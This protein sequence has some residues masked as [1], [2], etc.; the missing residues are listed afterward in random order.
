MTDLPYIIFSNPLYG[1]NVK[2]KII[3][4]SGKN[5]VDLIKKGKFKFAF[6]AYTPEIQSMNNFFYLIQE[7]TIIN[8]TDKEI[9]F[10]EEFYHIKD[11]GCETFFEYLEILYYNVF[12]HTKKKKK[13]GKDSP[14]VLLQDFK[15]SE[16]YGNE[17]ENFEIFMNARKK[18]F[19]SKSEFE[20]AEKLG[21][22]SKEEFNEFI[23]SGYKS[24]EDYLKAQEEGFEEKE[25]FYKAEKFGIT[26]KEN[27]EDF[28]QKYYIPYIQKVENTKEDAIKAFQEERYSD[29]FQM[30]YII[31][32]KYTKMLYEKL[33]GKKPELMKD[34]KIKEM[35]NEI[36]QSLGSDLDFARG[37]DKWIQ[38]KSQ[39]EQNEQVVDRKMAE[40]F[41]KFI[42]NYKNGLIE[43]FKNLNQ[44]K[45]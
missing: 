36:E 35:L 45:N 15:D 24:Y 5:M 28:K 41:E 20:R 23:N 9:H 29:F 14:K 37:I 3:D 27:Y 43:E 10:L 40:E 26:N 6:S 32:Q 22:E 4:L 44:N 16:F 13:E 34:L 38:L 21:I 25:E 8:A 17:T 1:D 7:G 2:G 30:Q 39:I 31:A 11:F 42:L 33:I 12:D 18:N 19:D